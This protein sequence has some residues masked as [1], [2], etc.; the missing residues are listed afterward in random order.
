MNDR[1]EFVVDDGASIMS[2]IFNLIGTPSPEE[3]A[4]C[5]PN[6]SSFLVCGCV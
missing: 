5:G 6:V 4:R 3:A 1:Y 2:A